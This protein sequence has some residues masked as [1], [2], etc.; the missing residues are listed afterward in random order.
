VRALENFSP[1]EWARLVPLQ[2]ALKQWRNDLWLASYVRRRARGQSEF[3]Q[4]MREFEGRDV[5]LVIAFEQPWALSWLIEMAQRHLGDTQLIVFDNSRNPAKRQEIEQVCRERA[6]PYLALPV[7]RT[8]HVNRSH[9]M[10]MQW[11]YSNV[12]R[13]LRP[14]RFAFLDHDLIPIAPLRICDRLG[15]QPVFGMKVL[16]PWGWQLWAGYCMFDLSAIGARRLN[17]NYDFSNGLDTGG[18]NFR[19]L[20]RDLDE[21]HMRFAP[22]RL[23]EVQRPGDVCP[24]QVQ[25]VDDAWLHIGGI[26]Y[27]DN[28]SD[29]AALSH[30]IADA[31]AHGARW[32]D[33]CPR[34][35]APSA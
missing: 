20:Y 3:M 15:S 19:A 21:P 7:N 1:R 14:A 33:L 9:G 11:V 30:Y 24:A 18:R 34:T 27:N 28:F 29:K 26:S 4:K 35:H 5:A 25:I 31:M 12:V 16:S 6:T 22:S 23:E 13:K 17:F 8:R 32:K 10:A 2:H